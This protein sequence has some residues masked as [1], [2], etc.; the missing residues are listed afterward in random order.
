[1]VMERSLAEIMPWVMELSL[2]H[3]CA[4]GLLSHSP[5]GVGLSDRRQPDLFP[6]RL[7]GSHLSDLRLGQPLLT[8]KSRRVCD[9]DAAAFCGGGGGSHRR[10][11]ARGPGAPPDGQALSLIHILENLSMDS[12]CV[13]VDESANGGEKNGG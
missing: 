6:D 7:A 11:P 13:K 4:A 10:P 5:G 3:I 1:M 12:T 8:T 2:I 9:A